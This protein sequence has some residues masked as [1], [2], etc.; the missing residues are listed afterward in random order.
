VAN[1]GVFKL[2]A[3][4]SKQYKRCKINTLSKNYEAIAISYENNFRE[5]MTTITIAEWGNEEK[6]S[7]NTNFINWY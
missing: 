7:E 3:E 1:G 2:S 6:E 4:N 5:F